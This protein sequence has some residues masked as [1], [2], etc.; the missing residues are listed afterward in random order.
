MWSPDGRRI[1]FLRV[2]DDDQHIAVLDLERDTIVSYFDGMCRMSNQPWSPDG[3]ELVG[4]CV[5]DTTS[6]LVHVDLGLS[7]PASL[8]V[9]GVDPAW[10][11]D[12]GLLAFVRMGASSA[13]VALQVISD[14]SLEG[15]TR[16]LDTV[17][18]ADVW[19]RDPG[20]LL[21]SGEAGGADDAVYSYDVDLG[22]S[23]RQLVVD[24]P[25]RA[26]GP[27]ESAAGEIAVWTVG[28]GSATYVYDPGGAVRF[29]TSE[30]VAGA[31]FRP[32]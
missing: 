9:G 26:H 5:L 31:A 4:S 25:G 11:P 13:E 30:Q 22:P 14:G 19:W 2:R 6:E 8:G 29:Q 23:S 1:A 21:V 7:A 15:S 28:A 20:N 27:R 16:T 24:P 3:S 18:V 10:S 17:P 32:S 12:G